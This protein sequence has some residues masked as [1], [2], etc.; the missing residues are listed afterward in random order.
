MTQ[1]KV[2]QTNHTSLH[3]LNDIN[4][5]ICNLVSNCEDLSYILINR[6]IDSFSYFVRPLPPPNPATQPYYPNSAFVAWHISFSTLQLQLF[7]PILI[8]YI[9]IPI[10]SLYRSLKTLRKV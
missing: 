8:Y 3:A 9:Y 2:K 4:Y 5:V 6:Y 10:P 1:F 7:R